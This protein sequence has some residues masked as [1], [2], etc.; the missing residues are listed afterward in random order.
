MAATGRGPVIK[1]RL[2]HTVTP[3]SPGTW[4][5]PNNKNWF[6]DLLTLKVNNMELELS[7]STLSGLSDLVEDE[8]ISAPL[9]MEV[10]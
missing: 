6:E 1:A 9:P 2:D 7:L 5:G 10:S 3:K 4:L 8:I